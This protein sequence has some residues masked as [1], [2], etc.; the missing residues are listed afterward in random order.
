MTDSIL[1]SSLEA[2]SFII[3]WLC[4]G[5]LEV[6]LDLIRIRNSKSLKLIGFGYNGPKVIE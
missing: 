1:T 3:N 2:P 5:I 4:V 6:N